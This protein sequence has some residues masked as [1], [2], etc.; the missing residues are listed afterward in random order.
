MVNIFVL[1]RLINLQFFVTRYQPLPYGTHWTWPDVQWETP[2]PAFEQ[3]TMLLLSDSMDRLISFSMHM[4]PFIRHLALSLYFD[5]DFILHRWDLTLLLAGPEELDSVA[6][7]MSTEE[8][9]STSI[10]F[11]YHVKNAKENITRSPLS[12]FGVC[13]MDDWLAYPTWGRVLMLGK[14]HQPSLKE[15]SLYIS[16]IGRQGSS[17]GIL[18]TL[19][20]HDGLYPG[21]DFDAQECNVWL[22]LSIL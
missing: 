19:W 12:A 17:V 20:K 4:F 13:H 16:L 2:G 6:L 5:T 8:A 9:C 18:V 7:Q 21:E 22:Y 10:F 3:N 11:S 14:V 1:F 15:P